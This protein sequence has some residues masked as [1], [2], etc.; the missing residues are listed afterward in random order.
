MIFKI[1]KEIE[2]GRVSAIFGSPV[3]PKQ[4]F[5]F[6]SK[7]EVEHDDSPEA[8][9]KDYADIK[10]RYHDNGDDKVWIEVQN[11]RDKDKDAIRMCNK[12]IPVFEP[13][14]LMI[15]G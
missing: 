3:G 1:K 14:H 9:L 5:R 6:F 12:F 10:L 4:E 11:G 13:T 15:A 2:C 7:S 8:S